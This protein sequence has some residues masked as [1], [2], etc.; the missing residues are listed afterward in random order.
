MKALS[1]RNPWAW[2]I[3]HGF[4][5]IEN[6]DWDTKFRGTF[7]IHASKGMTQDEAEDCFDHC[8]SIPGMRDAIIAAYP[9]TLNWRNLKDNHSGGIIGIANLVHVVHERD[10]AHLTARDAPWF[11][12]KYG[13]VIEDARP[14]PFMPYKGQL[15]WF[16]VEYDQSLLE[17]KEEH[18]G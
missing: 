15:G 16:D 4:K 18:H 6:R 10:K 12:G 7:L 2:L 1:I 17:T 13:F 9:N 5:S 14:L 3:A 11:F 8:R